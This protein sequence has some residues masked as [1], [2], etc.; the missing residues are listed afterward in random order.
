MLCY[1]G[2]VLPSLRSHDRSRDRQAEEEGSD[3]EREMLHN[4]IILVRQKNTLLHNNFRGTKI[5]LLSIIESVRGNI[6]VVA[7]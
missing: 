1:F 5:S 6:F 2:C 7:C 4:D 3:I